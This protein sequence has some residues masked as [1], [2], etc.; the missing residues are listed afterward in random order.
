MRSY[1]TIF[2]AILI[3]FFELNILDSLHA[4]NQ[5]DWLINKVATAVTVERESN[6][7]RFSNGII[8]RRWYVG[9]NIGCISFKNL[10]S[11]AEFVRSIQPEAIVTIDGKEYQVGG[12]LHDKVHNYID[13]NWLPEMKSKSGAFIF[14]GMRESL[15]ESDIQWQP[16][17]GAPDTP[18]PPKGTRLTLEFDPPENFRQAIKVFVHYEMYEGVPVMAKWIEVENHSDQEIRIDRMT[19]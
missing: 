19:T 6:F 7:I 15:P 8:F 14:K 4:K 16:R 1:R 3:L 17:Y 9:E 13:T 10:C 5:S 18:F 11:D 2:S 12:I